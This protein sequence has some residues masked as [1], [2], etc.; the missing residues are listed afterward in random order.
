V[1]AARQERPVVLVGF[2]EALA[3]I[4]VAWSLDQSGF[5]VI[6][7]TRA[8][9]RP[10]VRHCRGV[11]LV[12]VPAPEDDAMACRRAVRR[13]VESVRPV[14]VQPLDDQA[15]WV[16][17]EL[18][19]EGVALA[20]PRGLAAQ[21]A[22]DKTAQLEAARKAGLLVPSTEVVSDLRGFR[23]GS[24]P[25][26]V[27]PGLAVYELKG[28]LHRPSGAVCSD[29][30]E[31]QVAAERSWR[32]PLLLQPLIRGV[33]EGLFGHV[34]S[35][36]V[37]AWSAHRRVRMVNVQGSASSACDSI[38]PD[39]MLK[40]PAERFLCAIGWRGLFMIEFLR[41]T[42]GRPWFM[43]LNGRPWGSM[44]LA[45]R[46]GF[47]YPAWSVQGALSPGFEPPVPAP[48]PPVR[49]RHLGMEIVHLAFVLRGPRSRAF[50]EWPGFL[51]S[52][53]SLL[54]ISRRDRLYNWDPSQPFVL[55]SDTVQTLA[56][57]G[58]RLLRSAR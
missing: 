29:V 12:E 37:T 7:F 47:E 8:G 27:K 31:I 6:A 42:G 4:E 9:A 40:A 51:G 25:V 3:A 50:T 24:W 57:F 16:C 32:P 30:R 53:A 10:A 21:V 39:E 38:P 49:C 33:G 58:R 18:D 14:A 11:R 56:G 52:L 1:R 46:G 44:A 41:D 34:G 35:R 23:P 2:G 13:L 17:M 28:A 15:V 54:K 19:V 20:G 55:W 48:S 36:G 5:N 26:V 43:E 22:L 45:R